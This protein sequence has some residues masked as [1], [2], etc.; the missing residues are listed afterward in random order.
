MQAFTHQGN[1]FWAELNSSFWNPQHEVLPGL[2]GRAAQFVRRKRRLLCS[3]SWFP[4]GGGL[5]THPKTPAEDEQNSAL[6]FHSVKTQ[7]LQSRRCFT[8]SFSHVRAQRQRLSMSDKAMVL[9]GEW[10]L[11]ILNYRECVIG[12]LGWG[13]L[14]CV[15]PDPMLALN[16][17]FNIYSVF[18]LQ[19]TWFLKGHLG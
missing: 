7:E 6:Y 8:T 18:Y 12:K 16:L 9:L 13:L 15:A 5:T 11:W 2:Q 10:V 4:S 1:E 19:P 3:R 17:Y 14:A